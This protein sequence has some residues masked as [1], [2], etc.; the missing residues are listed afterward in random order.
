VHP[1]P[2]QIL[3]GLTPTVQGESAYIKL[4]VALV[5]T[6]ISPYMQLYVQSSVVEKGVSIAEFRYTRVDV[7]V[8]TLLAGIVAACIIIATATTLFPQGIAITT[9]ED[10]A[11]ALTPIAGEYARILFGIGLLGASLLAAGIL[12]LSTTYM[13]SESLGFERGVSRSWS[14]AP[15]FM[16][17]FTV[18]IIFGA[19]VALI[20]GL[21]LID[22]LVGVYVLNGLLLPIELVAIVLLINNPELMG[23]H[24][25]TW[26]HNILVWGIVVTVGLLSLIYIGWQLF[27]WIQ[28]TGIL[29]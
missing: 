17:V 27:E 19:V 4:I 20:P 24:V 10:A 6:T 22:V 21:P 8:G 15:I 11:I 23:T 29:S 13:L 9:A 3:T 14:E 18:L 2:A 1:S 7:I 28:S 26:W 16:G 25:N 5:G 12:P